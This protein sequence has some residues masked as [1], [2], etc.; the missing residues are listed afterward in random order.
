M[1]T[2]KPRILVVDDSVE[3]IHILI[4]TLKS[5]YNITPA[6]NGKI[7]LDKVKIVKPDLILLDIIM[8][9]IDGYEVCR[10]LKVDEQTQ[11]IPVVFITSKS[12]AMDE[13]KAFN[14]GAVDFITKPFVPIVVKVRVKNQIDL[15]LK[16]DLLE[17]MAALDGLTGLNNRRKFDEVY[18]LEW[19]RA[20]RSKSD[21]SLIMIDI[22]HFKQ[23]NDCYGHAGGDVCLRQVASEF[24]LNI[25]RAGDSIARYGGEEFVV[26]LTN[27]GH[28]G[29]K[30]MAE[31]LKQS[32]E[33]LKIPHKRSS[34][35]EYVTIS[36]GAASTQPN[37]ETYTPLAFLEAVDRMLYKAKASGRN[38]VCLV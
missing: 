21:L 9:G 13:T 1:E 23:F 22:D 30:C 7:A 3:N 15:K 5:E 19:L 28:E 37:A 14:L 24:Q 25:V 34:V 2:A 36:L 8:P 26:I 16:S 35:S 38:R 32:I 33:A 20:K 10:R 12:D 4:E 18:P 27:T 11:S 29:A 31:K 6:R 17:Q